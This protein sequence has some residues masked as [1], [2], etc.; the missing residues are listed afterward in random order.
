MHKTQT[1]TYKTHTHT[2]TKVDSSVNKY[3]MQNT[4]QKLFS[5]IL[6]V[7][8]KTM[9]YLNVYNIS[10]RGVHNSR[11]RKAPHNCTNHQE[12]STV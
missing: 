9:L 8:M 5:G 3:H 2:D 6:A 4:I 7:T 12:V 1:S 11:L 10:I